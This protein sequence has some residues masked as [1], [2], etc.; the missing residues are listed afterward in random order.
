MPA[1][2]LYCGDTNLTNAA[3]YL[4][5]LLTSFGQEF[6][7]IPSDRPLPE[8]ALDA[9]RDLV[10]LSDFPAARLSADAQQRLV[11][12]ID[13]GTGLLMIGGWESY[14]GAGG[15][16]NGTAVGGIL[17]VQIASS[18]DRVNCDQP[19]LVRC[20]EDHPIT[21]DL[22]WKSRPP[23]IGGFNRFVPRPFSETLLEVDRCR[24]L[25]EGNAWRLEA[26]ETHPLLVVGSH[27]AGRTAAL[28]TDVAPHW[29]GGL[30]DWG[31]GRVAAQAAGADAVEV[32]DLYA[33]LFQQLI[34]W[35]RKQTK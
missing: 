20:V 13:R 16:W 14:H 34:T 10:I 17:P 19:A 12:L 8:A 35:T 3:A 11:E 18:D 7:Y 21:T 27:G 22:P 2:I 6:D 4:A 24:A 23:V 30:V 15:D 25:R 9:A 28:A 1:P 5:G 31:S 32:G 33:R 26:L 29:V